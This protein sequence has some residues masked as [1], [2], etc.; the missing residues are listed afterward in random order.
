MLKGVGGE[1]PIEF[2]F[3][4]ILIVNLVYFHLLFTKFQNFDPLTPK[5]ADLLGWVEAP[6]GDFRPFG[7]IQ[8]LQCQKSVRKCTSMSF[9]QLNMIQEVFQRVKTRDFVT[10]LQAGGS[11]IIIVSIYQ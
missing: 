4:L 5:F 8:C 7:D 3:P 6:E 1:V 2:F 10:Y 9:K 11:P